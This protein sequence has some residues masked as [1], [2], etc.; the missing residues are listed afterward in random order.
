[1]KSRNA[2]TLVG[3]CF[4]IGRGG[5]ANPS[6]AS[7]ENAVVTLTKTDTRAKYLWSKRKQTNTHR[8]VYPSIKSSPVP[9]AL[10]MSPTTR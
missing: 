6:F 10:P 8:K 7:I 9:D 5:K 4:G 3:G 2:K 1:M